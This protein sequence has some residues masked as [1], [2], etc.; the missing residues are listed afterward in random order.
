MPPS[1]RAGGGTVQAG[2]HRHR[3]VNGGVRLHGGPPEDQALRLVLLEHLGES[4]SESEQEYFDADTTP[5]AVLAL[6]E[7][8]PHTVRR[9]S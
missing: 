8:T 9:S 4:L 1:H 6:P 5:E 2:Q 3:P 7:V